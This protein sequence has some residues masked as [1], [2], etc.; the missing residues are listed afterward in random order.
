MR[1]TVT[2]EPDVERLLRERMH[3]EQKSFKRALNDALRRGLLS[4]NEASDAE[5]FVL[6]ARDLGVR[7]EF[8][9][10]LPSHALEMIEDEEFLKQMAQ[11]ARDVAAS[12]KP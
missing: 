12:K 4:E 11:D 1:T 8:R 6:E 3:R 7:E 5:P 10:M 2:L 9:N